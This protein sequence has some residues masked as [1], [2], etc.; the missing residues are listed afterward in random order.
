MLVAW[1]LVASITGYL[2]YND[3]LTKYKKISFLVLAN[4]FLLAAF[5]TRM[6]AI[7]A[8][9]PIL[10]YVNARL[11]LK[12]NVWLSV[13][14][15]LLMPVVYTLLIKATDAVATHPSDSMKTYHLLGLSYLKG[16]NL[17]PGE[18][19]DEESRKIIEAC[20]TPVQWDTASLW[21]K[22][23]FIQKK[24]LHKNIWGSSALTKK[25]FK[26]SVSNPFSLFS[27]MSFTFYKSLYDPN[28][29]SMFFKPNKSDLFNWEVKT[30]PPRVS[31]NFI[32][33]YVWSDIN[34]HAGRPWFFA[35]ISIVGM[36]I[37]FKYNL[38]RSNL[39]L[40]SFA[41]M[42]SGLVYLL[43][44]FLLTV[45]AEYRYFYWSSYSSY[46]GAIL[47][48]FAW[49]S[50]ERIDMKNSHETWLKICA[51]AF[52]GF[53]IGLMLSRES[54]PPIQRTISIIPL[55]DKPVALNYLRRASIPNWMNVPIDGMIKP[56]KWQIDK[57]GF[58]RGGINDGPLS[59]KIDTLGQAIEVSYKTGP[60]YGK[61]LVQIDDKEI[62]VDLSQP[63]EKIQTRYIWPEPEHAISKNYS[64]HYR[65]L[66][67][68]L[69]TT[70][71]IGILLWYTKKTDLRAQSKPS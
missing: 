68:I 50:K 4:I 9:L 13:I 8:I 10:L 24:L 59:T 2:S 66:K 55:E 27:I 61:A 7:F 15:L 57:E 52:I 67:V 37:I 60:Q 69:Y 53:T 16:E 49:I 40:F 34:D 26:E 47:I 25:W 6:N 48:P 56:H 5:L 35:L 51:I 43:S 65:L 29:R 58:Y 14:I 32:Q 62:I 3:D 20:Y 21:G 54:L 1:L 18:W 36:V 11:G 39:G 44:Y 64:A 31:T 38:L 45:S 42:V 70:I 12:R 41:L 19:S 22:C 23:G 33:Q 30:D 63:T 17:L 28:S 46:L 71:V